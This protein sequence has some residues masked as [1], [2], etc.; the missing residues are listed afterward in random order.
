MCDS[1][2]QCVDVAPRVVTWYALSLIPISYVAC[3]R[4]TAMRPRGCQTSKSAL[5]CSAIIAG[6]VD[7]SER[8]GGLANTVNDFVFIEITVSCINIYTVLCVALQCSAACGG[9]IMKRSV[10]CLAKT[11]AVNDSFCD[12]LTRPP[13]DQ[14]CNKQACDGKERRPCKFKV[15]VIITTLRWSIHV[16]WKA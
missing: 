16:Y 8:F 3:L 6:L 5:A 4:K 7:L 10:F 12:L 1:A 2:R 14:E 13:V 11:Q 15:K 9:G